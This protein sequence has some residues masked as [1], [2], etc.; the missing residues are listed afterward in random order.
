[1]NE[2]EWKNLTSTGDLTWSGQRMGITSN[3]SNLNVAT[4]ITWINCTIT[5]SANGQTID[6]T[7]VFTSGSST[8]T[9]TR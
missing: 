4:G 5:M 1:L 8:T 2:Q 7:A 9:W 3:S 6:V